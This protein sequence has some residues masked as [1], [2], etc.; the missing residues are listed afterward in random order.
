MKITIA[1][2]ILGVGCTVNECKAWSN[3]VDFECAATNA[4]EHVSILASTEFKDELTNYMATAANHESRI[5][6]ELL[7]GE[8]LLAEYNETMDDR[9][10]SNAL[11]V[12][13]NICAL[14][15]VDT[16]AWYCWHSKLLVFACH[17]QNDEMLLAYTVA[18]NA[19]A[20]MGSLD[21]VTDNPISLSLLKR[22]RATDLSIRQTVLLAKALAAAMLKRNAEAV[23]LSAS[24]PTKYRDMVI[25]ALHSD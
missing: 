16:N 6:A 3:V 1:G 4:L 20:A 8:A 21:V 19:L 15:S 18:S 13:T 14:T 2:L 22:N 25:R 23:G 24:L 9:V 10:L 17:A 12:A 11:S 7:L 5:A